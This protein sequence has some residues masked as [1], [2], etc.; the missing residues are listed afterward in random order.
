MAET[1]WAADLTKEMGSAKGAG[2]EGLG[3]F[4]KGQE[5]L[6]RKKGAGSRGNNAA[7]KTQRP[8][9]PPKGE[10]KGKGTVTARRACKVKNG[11][12]AKT[13]SKRGDKSFC[14]FYATKKCRDG[15][16]CR[17]AYLC[18]VM[19]SS[20]KVCEGR[21]SASEHSGPFLDA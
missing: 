20:S 6:L 5:A 10:S 9:R 14:S 11:K 13:A 2:K 8:D 1:L 18:N 15:D 17:F 16:K 7:V 12:M 21:H 19:T 3:R 4:L